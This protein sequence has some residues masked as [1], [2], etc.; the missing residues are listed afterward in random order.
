[1]KKLAMPYAA[2]L[3]LL[4]G[5]APQRS[6]AAGE[7]YRGDGLGVNWS[8]HLHDDHT[9]AFVWTGCVGRYGEAGG[10]WRDQRN[11]VH[12]TP[13]TVSGSGNALPLLYCVARLGDHVY[14]IPPDQMPRFRAAVKDH[15]EPRDDMH[16]M[17]F[18]R[19]TRLD[20]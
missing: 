6:A 5:A 3:L 10:T 2:P 8:L 12:L 9:F 11:T 1:M 14:L 16:G 13:T 17:F 15:S 19:S 20:R 18:L 7:Y 4:L